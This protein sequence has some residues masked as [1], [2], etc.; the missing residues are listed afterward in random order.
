M[1]LIPIKLLKVVPLLSL[2]L[3]VSS[4][5]SV[6]VNL[7]HAFEENGFVEDSFE[8]VGSGYL[9]SLAINNQ[10]LAIGSGRDDT[11]GP[12]SGQV[13][14]FDAQT[15]ELLHVINAPEPYEGSYFGSSIALSGD[16]LLVGASLNG[17]GGSPNGENIVQQNGLVYLYDAVSGDH[18][19]TF[20]DPTPAQNSI[21]D[22]FGK[23]VA[24]QDD[25]IFVGAPFHDIISL[26]G[27]GVGE[28][29]L[30]DAN[31]GDLIRTF[32][33]PTPTSVDRFGNSIAVEGDY[34]LVG[35]KNHD[36]TSGSEEGEAH[37]FEI[38]TGNLIRTFND[39][40]P[41]VRGEFGIRV[42]LHGNLA[43]ISS[44]HEGAHETGGDSEVYLFDILTGDHLHTFTDPLH[45]G[46][47]R[48][49]HGGPNAFVWDINFGNTLSM[50][51]NYLLIGE[52]Y[53]NRE[54]QG[55]GSAYLYDLTTFEL[56][57]TVD[58]PTSDSTVFGNTAA[59]HVNQIIVGA[60]DLGDYTANAY[61]YEI[62]VPEP[63]SSL[64]LAL[65]VGGLLF[66]RRR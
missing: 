14:L 16:K 48:L 7:L 59:M 38:S 37:L 4:A 39:P 2:I 8:N 62:S 45:E 15:N 49:T 61:V 24:M 41:I 43:A 12:A 35:A 46:D 52:P 9:N 63:G 56:V 54:A 57:H 17:G 25:L 53:G 58:N 20:L 3:S 22:A 44:A 18:L 10:F 42:E 31:T 5:L 1:K 60:I 32:N 13:R 65:G 47:G 34:L 11:N 40:S 30:F 55:Y 36:N 50:E 33:D 27:N 64:L 23:S 66:R 6:E 28:V 26:R 19:R 21:F 29:H 51:E